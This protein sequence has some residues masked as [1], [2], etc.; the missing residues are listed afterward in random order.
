[1]IEQRKIDLST[2][3]AT[4]VALAGSA[5]APPVIFLHGFP[6]FWYSWRR[7]LPALASAGP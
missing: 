4:N 3:I 5:D 7:Q 6:E 1:M 2:G